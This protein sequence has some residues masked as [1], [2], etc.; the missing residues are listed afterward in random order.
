[1]TTLASWVAVDSRCPASLYFVSD[2]RITWFRDS[3]RE[4]VEATWDNGRKTFASGTSATILGYAGDVLLPTQTIGQ[5]TALI[6]SGAVSLEG[7][8]P[9][10]KLQWIIRSLE[11]SC[12]AYPK[13]AGRSF[14]LLYGG[15]QGSGMTSVF[16]AFAVEFKEGIAAA[17]IQLDIPK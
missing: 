4:V 14:S 1:M 15:R 9:E 11:A 13:S 8:G 6:D 17:P 5:I 7:E 3:K 16:F 12:N 10:S 2:S